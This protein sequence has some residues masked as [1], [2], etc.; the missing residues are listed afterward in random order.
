MRHCLQWLEERDLLD[1]ETFAQ[2]HSRDRLRFSPRSPF[3]LKRELTKKGVRASLAVEV[4]ERVFE[5]E[6]VGPVDLAV[7]AATGWVKR[8]SPRTRAALLAKRFSPEREKVRRR[9]YGFLARRGFKGDEAR[10]GME[11]GEEEARELEE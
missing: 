1:D 3:L 10:R 2:A 5:E 6:G 8:Q 11:A 4:I 7:Q 9:L